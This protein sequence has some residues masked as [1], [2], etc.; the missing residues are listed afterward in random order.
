MKELV[1]VILTLYS[2]KKAINAILLMSGATN[3]K[4]A[5]EGWKSM[6]EKTGKKLTHISK[7]REEEDYTLDAINNPATPSYFDT[8]LEWIGK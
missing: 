8:C 7:A 5:V 6:E 4:R 2:D 3:G 1:R